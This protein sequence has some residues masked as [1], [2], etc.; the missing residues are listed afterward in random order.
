VPPVYGY[1]YAV[2]TEQQASLTEQQKAF[3]EQQTKMLQQAAESQRI[4]AEQMLQQQ[5]KA[6]EL[7]QKAGYDPLSADP[8]ASLPPFAAGEPGDNAVP[9]DM[10]KLFEQA[11]ADYQQV[12]ARH[13]A[14]REAFQKRA[15]ERRDAAKARHAFPFASEPAQKSI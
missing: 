4:F 14:Q 10:Q 8:F 13:Q 3:A 7:V 6:A 5:A 15:E 12:K 11:N 2:G 1:P 9:A